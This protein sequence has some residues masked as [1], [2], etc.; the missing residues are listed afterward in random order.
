MT[1]NVTITVH[2][3]FSHLYS[4]ICRLLVLAAPKN[5]LLVLAGPAQ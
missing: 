5:D 2:Y 3:C 4:A 1:I